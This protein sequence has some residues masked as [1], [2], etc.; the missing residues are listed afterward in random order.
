MGACDQGAARTGAQGIG[1]K[2]LAQRGDHRFANGQD[3]AKRGGRGYNAGKKSKGRKRRIA[4][5]TQGNLLAVIVH[6]AGIQDR[7]TARAVPIRLFCLFA[8]I[9]TGFVD[10]SYSGA[11][12]DWAKSAAADSATRSR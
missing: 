7:V 9:Q 6:S 2:R 3:G 1:T 8:T 5:D 10:G 4:A 12:I 11:L